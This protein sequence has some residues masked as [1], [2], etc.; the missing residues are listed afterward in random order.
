M[1]NKLQY[2]TVT[3]I[4]LAY[5][6]SVMLHFYSV[7]VEFPGPDLISGQETAESE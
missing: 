1:P 5:E 6:H 7:C 4:R 3:E 2:C